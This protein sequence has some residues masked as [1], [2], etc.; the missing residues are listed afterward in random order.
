[1]KTASLY[2]KAITGAVV[3]ALSALGGY[4][5][6]DTSFGDISAGWAVDFRGNHAL[7]GLGAV[8]A[9]PNKL[10]GG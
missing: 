1:M 2:A 4:L 9:I 8:W 5:T 10:Q 6:N 3:A 7:V